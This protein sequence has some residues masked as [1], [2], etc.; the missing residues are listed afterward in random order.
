[1]LWYCGYMQ[2][3]VPFTS[4]VSGARVFRGQHRVIN[5]SRSLF[6]RHVFK[7]FKSP[8]FATA[9]DNTYDNPHVFTRMVGIA[10]GFLNAN[11]P[12]ENNASNTFNTQINITNVQPS[13]LRALLMA[14][15]NVDK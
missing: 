15:K 11:S 9:L 6:S 1:M 10:V 8:K 7:Y 2:V 3:Q 5:V 12:S 13:D 4:P 14:K